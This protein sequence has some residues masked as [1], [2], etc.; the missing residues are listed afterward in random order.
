MEVVSSKLTKPHLREPNPSGALYGTLTLKIPQRLYKA[1][2][3]WIVSQADRVTLNLTQY[4]MY[5]NDATVHGLINTSNEWLFLAG[6]YLHYNAKLNQYQLKIGDTPVACIIAGQRPSTDPTRTIV[7]HA[8][9]QT[10][11]NRVANLHWVSPSFNAF[12]N[13]RDP[14]PSGFFGVCQSKDW[15]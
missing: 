15:F 12:N 10:L 1:L 11:D 7:N 13:Q 9:G 8:N 3:I 5:D 6:V 14:P 2:H 4:H